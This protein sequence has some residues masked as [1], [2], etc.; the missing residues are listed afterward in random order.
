MPHRP[1]RPASYRF[2]EQVRERPRPVFR[3]LLRRGPCARHPRIRE[4]IGTQ[5]LRDFAATDRIDLWFR[6][7]EHGVRGLR[8][9]FQ[10]GL[11]TTSDM[12]GSPLGGVI[13]KD[14]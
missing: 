14:D 11:C 4:R 7:L 8:L 1:R 13:V 6:V 12:L 9:L 5:L 2:L 10:A 3:D